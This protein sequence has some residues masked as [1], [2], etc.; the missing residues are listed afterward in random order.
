MNHKQSIFD[1]VVAT[2]GQN[3]TL[4]LI[5]NYYELSQYESIFI[6]DDNFKGW[7]VDYFKYIGTKTKLIS[8]IPKPFEPWRQILN[9]NDTNISII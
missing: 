7:T 5:D 8:V 4:E 3:K 6:V 1:M 9:S 2:H